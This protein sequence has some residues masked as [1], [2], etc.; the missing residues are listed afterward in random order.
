MG[1]K[2]AK[3]SDDDED[4]VLDDEGGIDDDNDEDEEY[5]VELKWG[6]KVQEGV[7][8]LC[9]HSHSLPLALPAGG[10]VMRMRMVFLMMI[11]MVLVMM[12]RILITTMMMMNDD[13]DAGSRT[14]SPCFACGGRAMMIMGMVFLMMR[15]MK[16]VL[17]MMMRGN[18]MIMLGSR[19][20]MMTRMILIAMITVATMVDLSSF[21][22][23]D[24]EK[25]GER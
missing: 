7:K 1:E 14:H 3:R 23:V 17:M 22:V 5:E 13:Y 21:D 25:E 20:M 24:Y 6:T 18:L 10:R 11:K 9:W 19:G 12:M 8:V 4:G 16:M 2:S 15:V